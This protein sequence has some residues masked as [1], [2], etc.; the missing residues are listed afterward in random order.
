MGIGKRIVALCE[1]T[2]YAI[3][4]I[5]ANNDNITY[6]VH[7]LFILKTKTNNIGIISS[8]IKIIV[9]ITNF[10]LP[11]SSTPAKFRNKTISISSSKYHILLPHF[12]I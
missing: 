12:K 5:T 9:Y 8:T 7:L 10:P 6:L 3:D 11:S 2:A 1:N 4:D